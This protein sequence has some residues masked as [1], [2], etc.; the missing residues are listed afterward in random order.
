MEPPRLFDLCVRTI[1]INDM[2]ISSEQPQCIRTLL[3]CPDY[4]KFYYL[5]IYELSRQSALFRLYKIYVQSKRDNTVPLRDT[6]YNVRH[7]RYV[8]YTPTKPKRR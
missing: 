6:I 2:L 8:Q 1:F 4:E 5:N 3:N 7:M